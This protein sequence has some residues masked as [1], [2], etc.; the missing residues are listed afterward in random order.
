MAKLNQSWAA[1]CLSN[2]LAV[3]L[4]REDGREKWMCVTRAGLRLL[5]DKICGAV[6]RPKSY[7]SAR[8]DEWRA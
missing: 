7:I 2:G 5:R 8:G 1:Q 3:C 6:Y 4:V